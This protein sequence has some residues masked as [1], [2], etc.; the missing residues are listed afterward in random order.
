MADP[1]EHARMGSQRHGGHA[2]VWGEAARECPQW[3]R[4]AK[5]SLGDITAD[6]LEHARTGSQRHGGHAGVSGEAAGE[7]PRWPRQAKYSLE[8]SR[9]TPTRVLVTARG[10][11]GRLLVASR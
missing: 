5:Y 9:Q 11:R 10:G 7:C 2:G 1:L 4:Q 3:P 6:P 8:T